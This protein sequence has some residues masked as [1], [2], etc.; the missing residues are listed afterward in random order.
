MKGSTRVVE[1]YKVNFSIF[2]WE[3]GG[4]VPKKILEA[5]RSYFRLF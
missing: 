1:V 5:L 2:I 4:K 3:S